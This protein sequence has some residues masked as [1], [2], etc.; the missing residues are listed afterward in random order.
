VE[1]GTN[2]G[3]VGR[4]KK[5]NMRFEEGDSFI[6]RMEGQDT[7]TGYPALR[8]AI[9][10]TFPILV[11]ISQFTEPDHIYGK[12]DQEKGRRK[13][14]WSQAVCPPGPGYRS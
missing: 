11:R 10:R 7:T 13:I 8:E 6:M 3:S 12:E 14:G 5:S 1:K 4:G 9:Q 2:H